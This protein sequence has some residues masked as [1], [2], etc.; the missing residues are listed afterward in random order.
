MMCFFTLHKID[1]EEKVAYETLGRLPEGKL[2]PS[3]KTRSSNHVER[4]SAVVES[5][6]RIHEHAC[7]MCDIQLTG[8]NGPIA[9][10][11]HIRGL[12]EPHNGP[13]IPSNV[14]CLCPNH[15][16]LFD[17]GAIYIDDNFRIFDYT[18]ASLGPLTRQQ[19]HTIDLAFIKYHRDKNEFNLFKP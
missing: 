12:G 7:Q 1:E 16:R 4:D 14:I 3:R 19:G 5:V 10:G 15:H 11:A 17:S 8:P 9:D 2:N 13:D 6:K 18:G